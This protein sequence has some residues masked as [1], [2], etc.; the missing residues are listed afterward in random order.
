MTSAR[1]WFFLEPA[2]F[3]FLATG[4][5]NTLVGLGTIFALKWLFA[6]G[7]TAAN[8]CG[9]AVGIVFSC[10][11]N[12]RWTF[13]SRESFLSIAPK[14]V[15]LVGIAYLLNLGVVHLLLRAG[16]DSYLAQ[17]L[18][19]PPYTLITYLGARFWVFRATE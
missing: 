5:L 11:V 19:V 15:A 4:V 10:A 17:S 18:G 2:F 1:P 14:Y 7:D 9:Y 16:M 13:R 3:R 8:V 6:V 12:S